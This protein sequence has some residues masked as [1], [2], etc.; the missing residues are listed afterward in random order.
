LDGKLLDV[1]EHTCSGIGKEMGQSA[2]A[3]RRG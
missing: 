3:P 1:I 2:P